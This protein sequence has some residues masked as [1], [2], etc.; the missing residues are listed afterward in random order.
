MQWTSGRNGGFSNAAPS[1]LPAPVV[2]GGFAP[3]HVNVAAQRRDPDSLLQF[4]TLL[5][6]RYREC[7][8]L[9]WGDLEI[10][11]QP[12]IA[13]MAHSLTWGDSRM[14]ALHNLGPEP[15]D[16]PLD[17]RGCEPPNTLVDLLCDGSIPIGE[18][19]RVDVPLEGYGY[20]WLRVV[21][22]DSRRLV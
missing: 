1:K 16:V 10:L 22:Q 8:E 21:E 12:H 13:V 2:E 3:R 11:D 19:G 17:L 4:I 20:R 5:T 7:P 15:L 9:G 6:R 14:I 18:K